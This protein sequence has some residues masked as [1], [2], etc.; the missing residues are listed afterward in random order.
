MP[1]SKL[2]LVVAGTERA[3]LMV[4]SEADRLSEETMLGAV[5]Y[6]HEQL[7]VAINAIHD[8]VAE[9]GKPAWDWQPPAKNEVLVSRIHAIAGAGLA[10]A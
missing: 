9:A 1:E 4:E 8:L 5:T 2:D 3:V 6:G 10:E 7:Q